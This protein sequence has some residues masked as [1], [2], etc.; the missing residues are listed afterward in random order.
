M[1]SRPQQSAPSITF[2]S[3]MGASTRGIVLGSP[4]SSVRLHTLVWPQSPPL[5]WGSPDSSKQCFKG[6]C[7]TTETVL[8]PS[9]RGDRGSPSIGPITRLFQ[10]LFP[11]TEEGRRCTTHSRSVLSEP[12]P[13]Q[14][15]VQDVDVEDYYVSD[16]SGRLV[17]HGRP[18]IC[19]FIHSSCPAA[20]EV[21]LFRFW[22]EGLSIQISS[23]RPGFGAKDIHKMHGCCPG[24][25]EA[26][27]HSCTQLPGWLDHSGPLQGISELSQGCCPPP[28]SCSWSQNKHQEECSLPL[29]TNCVFVSSLGF[30]S[31]ISSLNACPASPV[32]PLGLLHMRPFLWWINLLGLRSTRPAARLISVSHSCFRTL[33]IWRS[34]LFIQSEVRMGA[35]HH[36]QMVTM[37]ASLTG[38]GAVFEDRRIP[39]LAHKLPGAES[40]LPGT[41]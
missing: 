8:P 12:L 7:A 5:R 18:E 20:Q 4:H 22:R 39:L 16:S 31:R 36:R 1:S 37:D 29:S 41:D 15:E 26:L 13:L 3:R 30:L 28:R 23:L 40:C 33:S 34:L 2:L 21:P 38:W 32:L 11:F 19:L 27:G 6:F 10:P 9:Q 35:I 14:R 25:L 24:P 17:C